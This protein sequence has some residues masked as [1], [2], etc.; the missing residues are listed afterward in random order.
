MGCCH[1]PRHLRVL[2]FTST[3]LLSTFISIA[4]EDLPA[5]KH[6]ASCLLL[7]RKPTHSAITLASCSWLLLLWR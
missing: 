6:P 4:T 2:H 5:Y 7:Q 3:S 1:L